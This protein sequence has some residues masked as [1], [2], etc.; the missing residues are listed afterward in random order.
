[1]RYGRTSGRNALMSA[2]ACRFSPT[3]AVVAARI[4][5]GIGAG[6]TMI[7]PD[8]ASAGA[9]PV[10]VTDPVRLEQLLAG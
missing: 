5:A 10:Y 1:M 8:D 4:V 6:D 9:G 3:P 2:F 7:W